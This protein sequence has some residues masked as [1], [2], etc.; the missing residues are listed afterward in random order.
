MTAQG[1]DKIDIRGASILA[2]LL[3]VQ[4]FF[5]SLLLVQPNFH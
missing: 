3:L 2:S 4:P 1:S 5:W